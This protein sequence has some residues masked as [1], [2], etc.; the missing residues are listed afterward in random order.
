MGRPAPPLRVPSAELLSRTC[1]LA[2]VL[3]TLG[4]ICSF[5]E[6]RGGVRVLRFRFSLRLSYTLDACFSSSSDPPATCNGCVCVLVLFQAYAPFPCGCSFDPRVSEKNQLYFHGLH[7][8]GRRLCDCSRWRRHC[9]APSLR[10]E[11]FHGPG[12]RIGTRLALPPLPPAPRFRAWT[13]GRERP[14]E[15]GWSRELS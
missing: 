2:E 4:L 3:R 1:V 8:F 5:S 6:L 10:R 13:P 11:M 12:P 15:Q 14:G 9:A 7:V